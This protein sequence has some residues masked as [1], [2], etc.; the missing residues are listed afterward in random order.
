MSR[1]EWISK[2][3]GVYEFTTKLHRGQIVVYEQDTGAS[4][5]DL[6]TGYSIINMRFSHPDR[7]KRWVES[8]IHDLEV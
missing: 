2:G 6:K 7:A 5:Y 4:I 3:L 8:M 1:I